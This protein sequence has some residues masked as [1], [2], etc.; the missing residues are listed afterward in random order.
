M[1][2]TVYLV[3]D[4]RSSWHTGSDAVM[5]TL[6]RLCEEAGLRIVGRHPVSVEQ[7]PDD[8]DQADLVLVNGEGTPHHGNGGHL[9]EALRQAQ[10]RGQRTALVNSVWH[11]PGGVPLRWSVTLAACNLLIARDPLSASAM[12]GHGGE[13]SLMPDLSLEC[14]KDGRRCFGVFP[15]TDESKVI[16][17]LVRAHWAGEVYSLASSRRHSIWQVR[18]FWQAVVDMRCDAA[19]PVAYV[20]SEHH[21]CYAAILAGVPFVPIPSNSWKIEG[22]CAWPTKTPYP[23]GVCHS[24]DDVRRGVEQ[25]RTRRE[26]YAAWRKE[27]LAWPH[28]T[29]EVLLGAIA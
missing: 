28:M 22:L 8:M 18:R 27:F 24:M 17:G 12:K 10:E 11:H 2:K 7:L 26:Q 23:I 15:L 4:T 13:P 29:A 9:M 1:V 25:A 20:T 14:R 3:N 19:P 21:G 5:H 6:E 16:A